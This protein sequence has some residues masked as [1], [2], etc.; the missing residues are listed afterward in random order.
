MEATGSTGERS[1][2]ATPVRSSSTGDA[3][4]F[5]FP[6][7]GSRYQTAVGDFFAGV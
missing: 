7:A 2:Q 6:I 3:S 1:Q 5:D 4:G